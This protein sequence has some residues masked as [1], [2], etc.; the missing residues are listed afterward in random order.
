MNKRN[1]KQ[2][3][4]L[5]LTTALICGSVYCLEAKEMTNSEKWMEEAKQ[6]KKQGKY[7]QVKQKEHFAQMTNEAMEIAD[8]IVENHDGDNL[9]TLN[10]LSEKHKHKNKKRSE[11]YKYS[12]EGTKEAMKIF[13]EYLDSKKQ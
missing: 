4:T 2:G 1:N 7:E 10:K 8:E 11:V 9:K 5:F 6:L 13:D 3:I 12:A